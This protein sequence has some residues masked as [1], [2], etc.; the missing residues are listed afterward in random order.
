MGYQIIKSTDYYKIR[1]IKLQFACNA[2]VKKKTN[3]PSII[4]VSIL[5]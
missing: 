2:Q 3:Y 1:Y 4:S 5:V